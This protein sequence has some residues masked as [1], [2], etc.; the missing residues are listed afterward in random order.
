MA[1]KGA[2]WVTIGLAT[3]GL[4]LLFGG[5]MAWTGLGLPFAKLDPLKLPEFFWYYRHDRRVIK[6]LA[7]GMAI[8]AVVVIGGVVA[9]LRRPRALHGDARFARETE[10]RREGMR[11][12]DGIVLGRKRGRYLIF[13]GNEHVLLEA[14]TR[15]GK[16]VGIV[17][18]NLLTWAGSVV[19]L[20]IKREN[21]DATAGFR[22]AHGQK[23]FLFN[24]MA[25][26]RA[27]ARYN[28]LGHIDRRAHDDVVTELQKIA[29]MLF[30]VPDRAD[31]FWTQGA[32][33]G[34]VGVGALVAAMDA[35]P[36]TLGEI[37]RQVTQRG[38]Q[39]YLR[40]QVDDLER[41]MAPGGV[42][43]IHDFIGGAENTVSGLKQTI[44]SRLNLW[45]DSHVDAATSASDFDL[46]TI[47]DER[48]SIYLGVSP[49]EL[50]RVAPLYNLFFQQLIDLNTRDL[51]DAGRHGI[52][53]LVLLDEFARLGRANVIAN[54]FSFVAGYGF[55][56][57]PVIQSRSQ[58]RA[59]YGNDVADEIVAN[60]GVEV[61]FTPKELKVAN[62]LSERIGFVGQTAT[63]KSRT[64]HGMLA[65]RSMSESDQRRALMLP[66][67][68]MQLPRDRMLILR[69]G[70]PPVMATKIRYFAS[71]LFTRRILA[72]PMV[73]AAP[74]IARPAPA[75]PFVEASEDALS[76]RT[77]PALADIA[78]PRTSLFGDLSKEALDTGLDRLDTAVIASIGI[79]RFP[80]IF[81]HRP[82][83]DDGTPAVEGASDSL[84]QIERAVRPR[85][86]ARS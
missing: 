51:P 63:T 34:F 75:M 44:T 41:H 78:P 52:G 73:A 17:I 85:E 68:L 58:L 4:V 21:W 26:D 66:Q 61:A 5:F 72:A 6:W 19:V 16:G 53:V 81:A 48:M 29:T 70:M 33:T 76:L 47:R 65:N 82:V 11:D 39:E 42:R 13:G 56:L 24:P 54:G 55:R 67:E 36:F 2:I 69:G 43:A 49:D 20:D 15:S 28:P 10:I 45:L 57:L 30:P 9:F 7:I 62:E 59:V 46:R 50:E 40:K 74:A 71:R 35:V 84:E 80:S 37:Y 12:S 32:I 8:A 14:P 3:L 86:K 23:V 38:T 79:E 31:P 77:P 25:R 83:A 22:R 27:T 60:C 64:I 1:S 18:P